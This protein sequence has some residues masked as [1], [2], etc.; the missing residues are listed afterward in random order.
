MPII[1]EEFLSWSAAQESAYSSTNFFHILGTR[2]YYSWPLSL[3]VERLWLLWYPLLDSRDRMPLHIV[4]WISKKITAP[5]IVTQAALSLSSKEGMVTLPSMSNSWRVVVVPFHVWCSTEPG[6]R[7]VVLHSRMCQSKFYPQETRNSVHFQSLTCNHSK[8][9][10]NM[11]FKTLK[12]HCC[13][14]HPLTHLF[15]YQ[16]TSLYPDDTKKKPHETYG[17]N[18]VWRQGEAK[19][20]RA[21]GCK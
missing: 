1:A 15:Y 6:L 2:L 7:Y 21:G 12:G 18:W 17:C 5:R 19:E 13:D 3:Y 9:A 16:S 8:D 20:V 14:Y 4:R 11:D 10:T